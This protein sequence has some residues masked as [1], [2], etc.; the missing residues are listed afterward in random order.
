VDSEGFPTNPEFAMNSGKILDGQRSELRNMPPE[1]Y[2]IRNRENLRFLNRKDDQV[3][4]RNV[5]DSGTLGG[6]L[7]KTGM[8]DKEPDG[9][10]LDDRAIFSPTSMRMLVVSDSRDRGR[11]FEMGPSGWDLTEGRRVRSITFDDRWRWYISW[12]AF[13]T[14]SLIVGISTTDDDIEKYP[15]LRL[16]TYELDKAILSRLRLP[17]AI[18]PKGNFVFYQIEAVSSNAL[19][20]RLGY[21][22]AKNE[23]VFTIYLDQQPE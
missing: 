19:L 4:W 14:E 12:K 16:Y 13:M 18:Q 1:G 21:R 17:P 9:L 3:E 20:L 10:F 5:G 2:Q 22:E 15:E 23:D 11:M 8:R 7:E 6:F